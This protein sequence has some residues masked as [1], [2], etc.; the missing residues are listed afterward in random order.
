MILGSRYASRAMVRCDMESFT[1]C[2][3]FTL[4]SM[5]R[6]SRKPEL[7]SAIPWSKERYSYLQI[8][9]R[10]TPL[11]GLT[12]PFIEAIIASAK[13]RP[14]TITSTG[15]GRVEA[16]RA[17]VGARTSNVPR[18]RRGTEPFERGASYGR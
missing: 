13:R 15:S 17:A 11:M 18:F 2:E 5:R 10:S 1:A 8:P 9:E 12:D 4:E 7:T 14:T 6:A 16:A 3:A